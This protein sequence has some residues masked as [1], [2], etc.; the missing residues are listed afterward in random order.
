[1]M[2][3]KI[4]VESEV[5]EGSVFHFTARF[6]LQKQKPGRVNRRATHSK[7]T[8][9]YGHPDRRRKLHLLLVEDNPINQLLAQRLI[10]KR[11]DTLVVASSGREALGLL[12]TQHFDLILMDIQMPEM[13]GIEVTAAIREK[14]KGTGQRIPIIA[15]TASAM[16]EDKDRCLEVGMDAYL[17]KPID[18]NALF[19]AMDMLTR[20]AQ[21]GKKVGE[22]MRPANRVFDPAVALESLD[23]DFDLLREVIGISFTQFTKH[24]QN[25][26]D[27]VAKEDP[28]LVERAAH[29]LKGTAANLLAADVM[30]AAS[31]LE[32]MGRARSLAGSAEALQSLEEELS[33]L[34]LALG[35]FEKEFV[36]P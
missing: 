15:T 12:E 8:A 24:M 25:I 6:N 14:E 5:G 26:R 4:W 2:G 29:S 11:G 31:R 34:Q 10:D 17:A 28:K 18:R 9:H 13:S 35:E 36:Q 27:G 33:K 21:P 32:E 7:S 22:R 1:M 20:P 23:G 30:E 19:E 16:K 3:G